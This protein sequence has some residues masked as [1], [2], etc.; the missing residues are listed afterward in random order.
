MTHIRASA[1]QQKREEVYTAFQCAAK[2][3]CL[4]EE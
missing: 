2:F 1:V 3:H 4:V